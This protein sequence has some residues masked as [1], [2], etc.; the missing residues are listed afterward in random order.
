MSVESVWADKHRIMHIRNGG[1]PEVIAMCKNSGIAAMLAD[2]W[3]FERQL[4]LQQQ[5]QP[6]V[7]GVN[8]VGAS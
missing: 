2:T 8:E 3:N 1:P 5:H 4:V 6:K 7:G